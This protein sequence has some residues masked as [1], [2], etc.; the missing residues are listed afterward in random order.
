MMFMTLE[1]LTGMLD[2]VFFPDAYRS[3]RSVLHHSSSPFLISG[4]IELD[5]AT[6]EPLLRAEK[7]LPVE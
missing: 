6:L 2:I 7:V 4:E 5:S 1:D 3:A